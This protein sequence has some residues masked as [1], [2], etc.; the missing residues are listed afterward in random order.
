MNMISYVRKEAF[1]PFQIKNVAFQN[2]IVMAPM[3]RFG[4]QTD[5]G[6]MGDELIREY[7]ASA[8]KGIGLII[9]QLLSVSPEVTFERGAGSSGGVGVYSEEHIGYLSRIAKACHDGNS[10]VFAQLCL[11]GYGYDSTYSKDVNALSSEELVCI[12][13]RFIYAARLCKKAGL[14]GVELHGAHT[15]FL[16]MLASRFSNKR[17]DKYGGALMGRLALAKEIINGIQEFSGDS[18]LIR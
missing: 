16:N 14:D 1:S 9:I 4:F 17:K 6:S 18:F 15:Y 12:R 13:N 7:T 11:S 10:R 5:K 3:V 2:R 8:D